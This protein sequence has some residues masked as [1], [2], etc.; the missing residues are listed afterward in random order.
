MTYNKTMA[1]VGIF[2]LCIAVV[3]I[4]ETIDAKLNLQKSTVDYINSVATKDKKST[5]VTISNILEQSIKEKARDEEFKTVETN[6]QNLDK[7]IEYL[8]L[9]PEIISTVNPLIDKEIESYVKSHN[10]KTPDFMK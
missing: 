1:Y 4:G 2:L 7:R 5:D 10:L 3:V 9:H 6:R 8:K